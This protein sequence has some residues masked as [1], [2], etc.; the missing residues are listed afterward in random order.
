MSPVIR[1]A[2]LASGEGTNAQALVLHAQ[3]NPDKLNICCVITDQPSAG[4]IARLGRLGIPI[5]LVPFERRAL[6]TVAETKT[7]HE[8]AILEKLVP[9]SVEWIFLAGYMRIL[10]PDF[11]NRF[12]PPGR[13]LSCILNIH[14]ALLPDFP[15]LDA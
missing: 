4:V 13:S 7:R 5:H 3:G 8:A 11:V 10:S 14:P 15:G 12:T 2:V 9:Y 6:E 1:A